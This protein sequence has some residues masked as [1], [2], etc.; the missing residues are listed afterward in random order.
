MQG[1][2]GLLLFAGMGAATP[3]QTSLKSK[4][5]AGA[6]ERIGALKICNLG[7]FTCKD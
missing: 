6:H 3:L 5:I 2:S 7:E 4:R 1:N